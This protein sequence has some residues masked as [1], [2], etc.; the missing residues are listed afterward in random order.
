MNHNFTCKKELKERIKFRGNMLQELL[1][2]GGGI[3]VMILVYKHRSATRL[4]INKKIIK[5]YKLP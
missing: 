5:I 3:Y 2:N 4:K 1:G